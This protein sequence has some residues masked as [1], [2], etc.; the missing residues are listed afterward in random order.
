MRHRCPSLA[1]GDQKGLKLSC[2]KYRWQLY[3]RFKHW[4]STSRLQL[5]IIQILFGTIII[6]TRWCLP[7]ITWFVTP[8]NCRCNDYYCSNTNNISNTFKNTFLT[9][10]M[11]NYIL[12]GTVVSGNGHPSCI[13][14]WGFSPIRFY[15]FKKNEAYIFP[16][17]RKHHLFLSRL[18]NAGLG[19]VL[20]NG[21]PF[22]PMVF[23]VFFNLS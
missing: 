22:F 9:Q 15:R 23:H 21:A 2:G 20:K 7:V 5:V 10:N 19:F 12:S 16:K 13:S 1:G 8:I 11:K 18:T 17:T 3:K 4:Q 14:T 6:Y